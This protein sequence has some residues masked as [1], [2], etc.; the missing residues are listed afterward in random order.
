LY[1]AFLKK[2]KFQFGIHLRFRSSDFRAFGFLLSASYLPSILASQ[3]PCIRM[4]WIREVDDE[5]DW[6]V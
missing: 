6:M 5:L 2:L 3:H 1:A 4:Q